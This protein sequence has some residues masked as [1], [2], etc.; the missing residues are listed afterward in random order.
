VFKD[1]VSSGRKIKSYL[2]LQIK[3]LLVDFL[4]HLHLRG[5]NLPYSNS[6]TGKFPR[7]S[8][9][10]AQIDISNLSFKVIWGICSNIWTPQFFFGVVFI[11]YSTKKNFTIIL[12]MA[13]FHKKIWVIS[14]EVYKRFF[15]TF[16]LLLQMLYVILRTKF[17][18]LLIINLCWEFF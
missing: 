1:G 15:L 18:P 11:S 10:I 6:Q 14:F 12:V 13:N 17:P 8:P 5:N 7:E 2:H 16:L 3:S 4:P 9:F